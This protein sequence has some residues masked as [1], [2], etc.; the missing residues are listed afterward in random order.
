MCFFR[1]RR[2]AKKNSEVNNEAVAPETAQNTQPQQDANGFRTEAYAEAYPYEGGPIAGVVM[3]QEVNPSFLPHGPHVNTAG[4]DFYN[5]KSFDPF[6]ASLD[7]A[8]RNE[9]TELFILRYK[10]D[11]PEIPSYVVGEKNPEF[12]HAIFIYLGKYRDRISS[13]LLSKIYQY[14]IK[15]S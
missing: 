15:I 10:G 3:A 5:C 1:K 8:E 13:N 11:M 2:K 7:T 9:F 12:F 14:S 4:Y 6:I